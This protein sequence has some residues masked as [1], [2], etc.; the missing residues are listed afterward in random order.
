MDYCE[1]KAE[2]L[3]DME[4]SD[5]FKKASTIIKKHAAL[6]D[7]VKTHMKAKGITEIKIRRGRIL[8][9]LRFDIRKMRRVDTKALPLEIGEQ[10]LADSEVWW[11]TVNVLDMGSLV[12]EIKKEEDVPN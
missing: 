12:D 7:G 1:K 6:L 4:Q 9:H 3:M 11:K 8:K 10:Y 2:E 5:E